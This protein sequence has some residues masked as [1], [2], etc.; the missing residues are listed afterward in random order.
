[1]H[2]N[3]QV[4]LASQVLAKHVNQRC[5]TKLTWINLILPQCIMRSLFNLPFHFCFPVGFQLFI[6]HHVHSSDGKHFYLS[7]ILC[8]DRRGLRLRLPG[9]LSVAFRAFFSGV[10]HH[11]KPQ[12]AV[13]RAAQS[14]PV[15]S[16]PVQ[17]SCMAWGTPACL[18][19]QLWVAVKREGCL[20]LKISKNLKC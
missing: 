15:P 9:W 11:C 19:P 7:S 17:S 2:T 13:T 18:K 3:T 14:L 5:D 4:W 10:A 1:M 12:P 8:K 6:L 16:C 20:D